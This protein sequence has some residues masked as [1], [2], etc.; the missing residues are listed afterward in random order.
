[1]QR[2]KI[3][4]LYLLQKKVCMQY[5]REDFH[6]LFEQYQRAVPT[7]TRENE[8][9]RRVCCFKKMIAKATQP[10]GFFFGSLGGLKRT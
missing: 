4:V 9:T 3:I 8:L 1:M 6:E 7:A 2:N 10:S 5:C